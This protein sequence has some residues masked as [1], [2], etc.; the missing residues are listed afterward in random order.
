LEAFLQTQPGN[1]AL[2]QDLALINMGLD[3]TGAAFAFAERAKTVNPTEKDAMYGP[4]STE[5][6]ARIEAR[7]GEPDRAVAALNELFSIP[8]RGPLVWVR[9]ITPSLLQLDP[10]FDPL[11]SNPLF[12]RLVATKVT[13]ENLKQ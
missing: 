2:I 12:Q 8:Y 7:L 11:R 6:L 10:M 9:P 13:P 3:D 4:F 1:F 5:I